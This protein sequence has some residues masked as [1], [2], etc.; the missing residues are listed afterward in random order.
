MDYT[1]LSF[2]R[3]FT[4]ACPQ[5]FASALDAKLRPLSPLGTILV[6]SEGVN[7]S[8]S[9]A[10]ADLPACLEGLRSV[11][12]VDLEPRIMLAAYKPFRY[13]QVRVK[14][15]IITSRTKVDPEHRPA[16]YVEPLELKARLDRGDDII[17]IDTRN[18]FEVKFGT[19]KGAVDPKLGKFT[20]WQERV[21]QFPE[22]WK[23]KPIVTF[24][25]GGIRCEKAA[26]YLEAAGFRKV[27][28][29]KGG[30]LGYFEACGSA[31]YEGDCFVFDDRVAVN[32]ELEETPTSFCCHC[33]IPIYDPQ[34]KQEFKIRERYCRDC[35]DYVPQHLH[36]RW[37]AFFEMKEA[38]AS[39]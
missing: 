37:Q 8:F 24:C 17:L 20:E 11:I 18:A 4:V 10:N 12:A 25:T 13:W 19:F 22:E 36:G 39:A 1:L 6:S 38:N 21:K 16:P 5:E 34:M 31:H 23:D 3:F 14:P 15:E 35:G 27:E 33:Q 9:V 26:P 2:Y 30:I 29:L 28:Q 32:G 7:G